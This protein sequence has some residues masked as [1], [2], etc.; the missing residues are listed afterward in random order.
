MTLSTLWAFF[1][2]LFRPKGAINLELIPGADSGAAPATVVSAAAPAALTVDHGALAAAAPGS[3]AVLSGALSAVL[4]AA[5]AA[6]AAA[7]GALAAPGAADAAA[8]PGAAAPGGV[9]VA[10]A[11]LASLDPDDE[12]EGRAELENLG[13]LV[14]GADLFVT[15]LKNLVS[16]A[17]ELGH[18]FDTAFD[19]AAARVKAMMTAQQ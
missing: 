8:A 2:A 19:A 5:G 10:A 12:D 13:T 18:D 4:D 11:T 17:L 14:G 7:L 3:A 1:C 15:S 6:G 16:F 9:L